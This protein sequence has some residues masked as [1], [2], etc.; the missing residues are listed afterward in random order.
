MLTELGNL[1]R[2]GII[3]FGCSQSLKN[4]GIRESLSS[5]VQAV[6]GIR[7]SGESRNH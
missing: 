2:K 1:G 3:E 6:W 5:I 4:Q 7:E